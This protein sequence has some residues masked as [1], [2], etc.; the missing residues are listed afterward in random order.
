MFANPSPYLLR[1]TR[2]NPHPPLVN[3]FGG[4]IEPFETPISGAI[5]ELHEESSLVTQPSSIHPAGYL[6]LRALSDPAA[7]DLWI[8][9]YVATEW[10]G[11]P[12]ESDEMRPQWFSV[13][14]LPLDGM[15]EET[16]GWMPELL[17]RW[18]KG[19]GASVAHCVDFVGGEEKETGEWSIW[20]GLRDGLCKWGKMMEVDEWEE[21]VGVWEEAQVKVEA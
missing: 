21:F 12:V 5:R 2:A 8:H 19:E 17:E 14:E 4:K 11:E 15:W 18:C 7:P 13:D 1:P 16:R 6:L 3:G 10:E 20:H 9:V